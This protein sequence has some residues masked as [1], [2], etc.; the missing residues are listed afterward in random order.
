LYHATHASSR[1]STNGV[2]TTGARDEP[3]PIHVAAWDGALKNYAPN[4]GY[5]Y[6]GRLMAAWLDR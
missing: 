4:I 2:T 6:A 1:R 3:S 5:D